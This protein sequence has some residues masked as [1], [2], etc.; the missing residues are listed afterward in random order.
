MK[1]PTGLAILFNGAA[2]L[3][4]LA[5]GAAMLRTVFAPE[6][7][8][9]CSA[10]YGHGTRLALERSR[11]ELLTAADLQARFGGTDWGL[12]DNARVV[13]VKGDVARPAIEVR[14]AKAPGEAASADPRN[15]MGFTWA[16]K[17]VDQ[18]SAACLTFSVLT[19]ADFDFA[20]GGRLPGLLATGQSHSAATSGQSFRTGWHETGA[21]EVRVQLPGWSDSRVLANDR[22]EYPL[23]RGQWIALEQEIVLNTPGQKDGAV[24]VWVDGAL[25]FEKTSLVLREGADVKISGVAAEALSHSPAGSGARDRKLWFSSLE[26]RWH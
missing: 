15:G 4:V 25:R 22:S 10:R 11:G 6:E 3:I 16:P 24:R 19:P 1:K 14:L 20:K 2:L 21:L 23:P 7:M 5:S 18:L 12:L 26:L 8:A 9:P 13:E 17:A